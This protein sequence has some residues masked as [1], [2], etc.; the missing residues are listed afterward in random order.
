MRM[1]GISADDDQATRRSGQLRLAAMQG[2]ARLSPMRLRRRPP[3]PA[4][5]LVLVVAAVVIAF[6]CI[7]ISEHPFQAA[8]AIS[9]AA[10]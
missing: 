6:A 7:C 9:A 4:F 10:H 5:L 3:L 8:E 1:V 2:A